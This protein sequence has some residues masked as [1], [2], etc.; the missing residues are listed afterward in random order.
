MKFPVFSLK[1]RDFGPSETGS[2]KTASSTGES[3]ELSFCCGTP[4]QRI[5]LVDA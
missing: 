1:N 4:H 3:S 2:L 5:P